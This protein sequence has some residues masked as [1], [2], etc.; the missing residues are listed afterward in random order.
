[1][2]AISHYLQISLEQFVQ[3]YV[4]KVGDRWSFLEKKENFS[5]IFLEDKKCRIYPVRP[6]QCLTFPWWGK[7]LESSESWEKLKSFC[8]GIRD[9]APL[10]SFEEIQKDLA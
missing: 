1:M 3:K 2:E 9:D 6:K 4:R 10:I 7:N 5:C 8:P